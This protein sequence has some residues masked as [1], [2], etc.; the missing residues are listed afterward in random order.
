MKRTLLL[1]AVSLLAPLG[2]VALAHDNGHE[3]R[4]IAECERLPGTA[5]SGDRAECLRCVERPIKHHYHPDA[6]VGA[7]CRP[8]DGKP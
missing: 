2:A 6:P 3:S 7:R 1:V 4:T 5:K 8:D